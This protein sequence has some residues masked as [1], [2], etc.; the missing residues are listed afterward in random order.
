MDPYAR[1]VTFNARHPLG[2]EFRETSVP[3]DFQTRLNGQVHIA[4][5]SPRPMLE[6]QRTLHRVKYGFGRIAAHQIVDTNP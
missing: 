2:G 1:I 4:P 6:R 3:Q 5:V